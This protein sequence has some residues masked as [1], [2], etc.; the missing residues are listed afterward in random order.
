MYLL[1]LAI[2]TFSRKNYISTRHCLNISQIN[3]KK[4]S[5]GYTMI[6]SANYFAGKMNTLVYKFA[7]NKT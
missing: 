1:E 2:T 7:L 4:V 3:I 5:C 6:L